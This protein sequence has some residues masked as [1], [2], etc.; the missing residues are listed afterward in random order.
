MATEAHRPRDEMV[1]ETL[2]SMET[3]S[4]RRKMEGM[5]SGWI[6]LGKDAPQGHPEHY[7]EEGGCK[8]TSQNT[9]SHHQEEPNTL[10]LTW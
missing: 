6:T 8:A 9:G 4:A 2:F 10:R 1:E 7:L 5:L 3:E